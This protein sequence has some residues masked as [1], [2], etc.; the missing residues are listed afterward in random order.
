ME[1][2]NIFTINSKTKRSK[3]IWDLTIRQTDTAHP[4]RDRTASDFARWHV[5]SHFSLD[6]FIKINGYF[7]KVATQ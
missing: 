4:V 2:L 7:E 1:N 3:F 6:N 5:N